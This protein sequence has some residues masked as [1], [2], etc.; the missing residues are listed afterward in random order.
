MR[1]DADLSGDD[2]LQA[3]RSGSD[4]AAETF[5]RRHAPRMLRVARRYLSDEG[6]AEDAVQEAFLA[7][8]R[9]L[10]S[11][12]GDSTLAGWLH[13]IVVNA[14]LKKI[15]ARESDPLSLAD[16]QPVFDRMG[17][18]IEPLRTHPEPP[19]ALLERREV[20]DLVHRS[21]EALPD[22]HRAAILLRDIEGY[23]TR[24]AAEL[25]GISEGAM[26]VRLHRARSALKTLLEP[27]LGP[28]RDGR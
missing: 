16:L 28:D 5:V 8:F 18:R 15:R 2:L 10:D 13:T 14:S 23:S 11:F 26:K 6:H 20:Q 4:Q 24:E 1:T 25:L 27:V 17:C 3:L 19:D 22:S 21:I 7:A 9:S 12:R